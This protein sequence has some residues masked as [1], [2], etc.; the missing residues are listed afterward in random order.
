MEMNLRSDGNF[1]EDSAWHEAERRFGEALTKC[2]EK[3]T[4]LLELGVGFNTPTIIRFPFE[5]LVRKYPDMSLIRLNRDEAVVPQAF[6]DR[7]IGINE[8]MEKSIRDLL[9]EVEESGK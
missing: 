2:K 4:A 8:D 5:K 7:A 9:R 1:V 3:K 6:G